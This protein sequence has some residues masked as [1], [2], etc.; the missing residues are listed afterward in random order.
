VGILGADGQIK[1]IARQARERGV[2]FDTAHGL[3]SLS[4]P[5]LRAA[6]EQDFVPDIISTDLHNG[7]WRGP[8]FD[9]PT[10]ISKFLCLGMPL[11]IAL[12]K[13]LTE[14]VR[15]WK[16]TEKCVRIE[17]GQRAD[18]AAFELDRSGHTYVDA[19][20]NNLTGPYRLLPRFTV[21]GERVYFP[22]TNN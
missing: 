16:L 13:A 1:D 9:L 11:H 6:M 14:P 5:V 12:A 7:N 17:E 21:L 4:F 20:G 8:V 19:A 22:M 18:L 2:I 10:T 3:N 15:I